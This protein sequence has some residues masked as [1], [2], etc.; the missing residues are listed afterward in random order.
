MGTWFQRGPAS[1][2]DQST[3]RHQ[4]P[5]NRK[6]TVNLQYME[7]EALEN[8]LPQP[9][10]VTRTNKNLVGFAGKIFVLILPMRV[11]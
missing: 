8:Q 9:S 4:T 11:V 3:H 6:Q 10:D 1:N 2:P 7:E 5:R